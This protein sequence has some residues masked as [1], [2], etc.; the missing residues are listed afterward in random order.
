VLV[1]QLQDMQSLGQMGQMG[2]EEEEQLLHSA[3][4]PLHPV[5]GMFE[6]LALT[7][8]LAYSSGFPTMKEGR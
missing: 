2:E 1:E 8:H 6:I 3:V 4:D 7:L 5:F